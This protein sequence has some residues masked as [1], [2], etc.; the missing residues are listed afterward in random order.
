MVGLE[1]TLDIGFWAIRSKSEPGY[2]LKRPCLWSERPYRGLNSRSQ[3][4]NLG[5]LL[6]TSAFE[7]G[8][9]PSQEIPGLLPQN[10]GGYFHNATEQTRSTRSSQRATDTGYGE[11]ASIVPRCQYASASTRRKEKKMKADDFGTGKRRTLK[12]IINKIARPALDPYGQDIS[13]FRPYRIP[14]AI[15]HTS[16]S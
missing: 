2:N 5:E 12:V 10:E 16:N 15:F 4:F 13:S 7:P 6:C 1:R 14:A 3:L 8:M 9:G 11:E